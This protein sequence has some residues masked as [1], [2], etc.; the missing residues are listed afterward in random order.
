MLGR[1]GTRLALQGDDR[2]LGANHS[3]SLGLKRVVPALVSHTAGLLSKQDVLKC[4]VPHEAS[5]RLVAP[6]DIYIDNNGTG[7]FCCCCLFVLL[8]LK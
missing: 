7:V 5:P 4:F 6:S 2:G 1:W 8:L 3:A